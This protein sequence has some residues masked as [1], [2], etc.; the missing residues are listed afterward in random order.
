MPKTRAGPALSAGAASS[1]TATRTASRAPVDPASVSPKA[2]AAAPPADAGRAARP[3]Q[4]GPAS[5]EAF[6]SAEEISGSLLLPDD[7]QETGS[8]DVEELSG[9]LLIEDPG[10]GDGPPL[11]SRL[12]PVGA[13]ATPAAPTPPVE[14]AYRSLLGIP[15]LPSSTPGPELPAENVAP[16]RAYAGRNGTVPAGDAGQTFEP[17]SRTQSAVPP[18]GSTAA[19]GGDVEVTTLPH[20]PLAAL[21]SA[22]R[23][24]ARR[25]D[26]ALRARTSPDGRPVWVL[27]LIGSGGLAVGVGLM[28]LI[29]TTTRRGNVAAAAVR[30]PA[31]PSSSLVVEPAPASAVAAAP[32][33][34]PAPMLTPCIANG[35]PHVLAPSATLAAGLEVR[36]S[37][38][39]VALGFAPSDHQAV[40]VALDPSSFT[41]SRTATVKSTDPVRRVTPIGPPSGPLALAVD[42]ERKGDPVRGRRTVVFDRPLQIGAQGGSLGWNQ[43][44]GG[45]SGKLWPLEGDAAVDALRAATSGV[46]KDAVSE[47]VF[48]S[49]G[50]VAF[51][52]TT[53]GGSP[54][55]KGDL[56]HVDGLGPAVGSPAVAVNDGIVLLAWADRASTG[57]PWR[58]RWTRF[59]AGEA[60]G[61]VKTFAPPPGG[62]G[63][64]IMSP[65]LAALPG[66]RFLLVWT[67]GPPSHHEVRALTLAEDGSP[68][69][70][71]IAVSNGGVNAGQGQAAVLASGK[72]VVAFLES[73]DDGF[74]VAAT[75]VVCAF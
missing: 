9:S 63:D 60:A 6:P 61:E 5:R 24:T 59:S 8:S 56:G 45:P 46:G 66:K 57:D 55:P 14:P 12:A 18:A 29:V 72:G 42:V 65:G 28:V 1:P 4:N 21:R 44:K 49:G 50:L 11:V 7:A 69:G 17:S 31:T 35:P 23:S 47:I 16:A 22:W 53:G 64:P 20:G 67:E 2:T 51:G 48:R 70:G 41:Q 68:I 74:Q 40:G 10:D 32:V 37:G 73:T 43:P 3:P 13:S 33:P 62:P 25:V 38:D 15:R 30:P 34:P 75:G 54:L 36:T 71:P 19:V 26:A 58:L 39:D 27:A 52:A